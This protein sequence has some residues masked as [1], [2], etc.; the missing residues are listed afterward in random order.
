MEAL[1][2]A[3][4]RGPGTRG[5]RA[6]CRLDG[7]RPPPEYAVDRGAAGGRASAGGRTRGGE[8]ER[9]R[10]PGDRAGH[11]PRTH[12]R[13]PQGAAPGTPR[14]EPGGRAGKPEVRRDPEVGGVS[15]GRPKVRGLPEVTVSELSREWCKGPGRRRQARHQG[16]GAG[17]GRRPDALGRLTLALRPP[18]GSPSER[19]QGRGPLARTPVGCPVRA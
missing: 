9:G 8:G 6:E 2:G 17:A 1:Q 14:P 12:H 13:S 10:Q 19:Q 4:L 7:L 15:E 18:R 5:G 3:G 11:R 16:D